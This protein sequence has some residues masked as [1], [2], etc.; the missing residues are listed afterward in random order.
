M[1]HV[2]YTLGSKLLAKT[3][4]PQLLQRLAYQDELAILMYH[5]ILKGPLMVN[6][7]C[8]V[9]ENSFGLQIGYLKKHFETISLSEAV[10]RMRN[11]EITHATAVITFDDGYQN[12]FDI[13]FPILCKERIPATIFL[14]TGLMNTNDTVWYCRLNLA[15]SK[16]QRTHIE[17]N[18]FKFDLSTLDLKAKAS[19]AIQDSL[20][21]LEH[22]NLMATVRSTILA[23]GDDPDSSIEDG[24]AF[25]MLDKKAIGEMVASGLIEFGAHTHRHAILSQ[26]SEEERFNEIRQSIDAVYELT[27]R[28]CKCFAYP[29]GREED[30]NS[31]TIKDLKACGIEIAVTAISGPNDEKTPVLELRRYGI[32]ADLLM[33]QFQLTVHHFYNKSLQLIR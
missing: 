21:K 23:L 6:D 16:T 27:G 13:A 26:L 19:A 31:E 7:W 25:R 22:T 14:T 4:I 33:D 9:D 32:G 30:Y 28:P 20:K 24:S 15:L 12:N 3:K 10:K 29:N 18:G 1:P 11:R 5:G 2:G 8:F 17:W